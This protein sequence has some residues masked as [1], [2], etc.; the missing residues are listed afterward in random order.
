MDY[1]R[2]KE[3]I[4]FYF[5]PNP[6]TVGEWLE[7]YSKIPEDEAIV[8]KSFI[9]PKPVIKEYGLPLILYKENDIGKLGKMIDAWRSDEYG[10]FCIHLFTSYLEDRDH[11]CYA[12]TFN[13]K[14]FDSCVI[15]GKTIFAQDRWEKVFEKD[16]EEK[17]NKDRWAIINP[18]RSTTVL[19]KEGFSLIAQLYSLLK[20]LNIRINANL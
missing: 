19:S 14:E 5:K 18:T 12:S 13:N 7:K 2:I 11:V 4:D 9:Q 20:N 3:A 10:K 15:T 17:E 6:P 8:I 16:L 1:Q